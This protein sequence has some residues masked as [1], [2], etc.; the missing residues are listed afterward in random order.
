MPLNSPVSRAAVTVAI[1]LAG[2]TAFA[3]LGLPL[4]FLFG[5]MLACP[6]IASAGVRLRGLRQVSVELRM[7]L[8]VA[9][10]AWITSE[11][12]AR[13]LQMMLTVPLIRSLSS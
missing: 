9:V 10:D 6:V 8:E 11:V 7:S 3:A 1:G 12:L 2:T 4:P 13:I 5:P